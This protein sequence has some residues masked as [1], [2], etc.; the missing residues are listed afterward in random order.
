ML[1][2][3]AFLRVA[4][5]TVAGAALLGGA[6]S[7]LEPDPAPT[8]V[9]ARPVPPEPARA[10]PTPAPVPDA[11]KRYR[12]TR[13][14]DAVATPVRVE[15]PSLGIKSALER[16]GRR[17]D[18][19]IGVPRRPERA[20]WYAEG[21]PPGQ[22][23]AAVVLGHVD[24]SVGPAVFYRL[25]TLRRG[26]SVVVDRA[27]G[28]SVRFVVDKVEQ[29]DKDSFPAEDVY[30][31]TVRPTLRLITCGGD[32]ARSAGG[33]QSNVIVFAS[34]SDEATQSPMPRGTG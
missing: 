25:H 31:P 26:S 4:V 34:L 22:A 33:Y 7:S 17:P 16:V 32:Y 8:T 14:V 11:V 20:A 1:S 21:A 9:T 24:S 12:S 18:G 6:S 5:L 2:R 23:G 10:E 28:S 29:H 30:F 27:D 13:E 15:I 3:I 19:T